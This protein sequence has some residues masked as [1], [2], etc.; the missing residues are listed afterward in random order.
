[1]FVFAVEFIEEESIFNS[2]VLHIYSTY[3][4]AEKFVDD[5]I[6]KYINKEPKEVWHDHKGNASYF[7]PN[8]F[9]IEINKYELDIN[10][11]F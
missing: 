8:D 5:Y 1:M 7:F 3:E 6:K 10:E 2:T 9:S 4:K 11:P